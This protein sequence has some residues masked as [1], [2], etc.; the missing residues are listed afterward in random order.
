MELGE[1]GGKRNP[2]GRKGKPKEEKDKNPLKPKTKGGTSAEYLLA[3]LKRDHSAIYEQY[4]NGEFKS[5]REAAITAGVIKIVE[6]I[7]FYD[8]PYY[9]ARE[10]Y[11]NRLSDEWLEELIECLQDTER[12]E[13]E[14]KMIENRLKELEDR[15]Q[16]QPQSKKTRKR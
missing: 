7:K 10:I 14:F 1:H 11:L 2:Y 5:V 15:K 12:F 9:F 6:K 13:R 4:K 8:K 3:R 16:D